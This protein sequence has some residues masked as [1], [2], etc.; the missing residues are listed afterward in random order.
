M[1]GI[2]PPSQKLTW[3][4]SGVNNLVSWIDWLH[5]ALQSVYGFYAEAI[6]S[7]RIPDS[8]TEEYE[9]PTRV[10]EVGSF[11]AEVQKHNMRAFFD[12]QR[13]WALAAPKMV[14]FIMYCCTESSIR[15][16]EAQHGAAFK[17]AIKA[18]K[19]IDVYKLLKSSHTFRGKAASMDDHETNSSTFDGLSRRP[20]QSSN[21]DGIYSLIASPI[22]ESLKSL[23]RDGF[24]VS[25]PPYAPTAIRPKFSTNA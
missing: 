24:I 22:L 25:L 7:E 21:D 11:A 12:V 9:A 23:R 19:P 5:I 1:Q 20:F 17:A 15:R 14:S 13:D 10:P 8:W 6:T 4:P 3:D 16:V 2:L 18:R